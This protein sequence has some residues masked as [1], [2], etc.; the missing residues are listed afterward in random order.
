MATDYRPPYGEGDT[1]GAGCD[2]ARHEIFFTK[3]GVMLGTAFTRVGTQ[4]LYPT[5]G[6]HSRGACVETNFGCSPFRFDV[7]ALER[8]AQRAQQQEVQS[9]SIDPALNLDLVRAFL[10]DHGYANTLAVLEAEAGVGGTSRD[11]GGA[12]GG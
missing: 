1:I 4:P 11:P 2:F 8:E 10:D 7:G 5:L 3:N 9:V 12:P 6:L